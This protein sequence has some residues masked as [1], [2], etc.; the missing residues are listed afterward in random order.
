MSFPININIPSTND[1]PADDQPIMQQNYANIAGF[2]AVDHV[3]A[4]SIGDGFHKQ[5]T[6]YSNNVPTLPTTSPVLFSQPAPT[7]PQ[8]FCYSGNA[9]QSSSQY[10]QANLGSTFAFA[11]IILKWGTVPGP[12]PNQVPTIVNFVTP[13]PNN[14]FVV[15]VTEA[16]TAGIKN[17]DN[18]WVQTKNVGDFSY[19]ATPG[20]NQ[21]DSFDYIAI[22]N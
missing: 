14:C 22:G 3:P 5:V 16:R 12:I 11:G 1:D 15:V 13:F 18:I 9:A 4:G 7:L 6:F 2:L 10:V 20:V 19:Y 17:G 21:F 8:P